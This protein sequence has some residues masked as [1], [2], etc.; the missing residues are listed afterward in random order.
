MIKKYLGII[1]A[2]ENRD[3]L[4]RLAAH[5][6]IAAIPVGGKYRLVD[7]VLSNMVNAGITS[8]AILAESDASSLRDH[9]GT[10]RAWDLNRRHGG[11]FVF[12]D[13]AK[14]RSTYDIKVLKENIEFLLRSKEEHVILS[15]T[16]L[17]SNFDL[18]KVMEEH[19]NSDAD[20]T[21]VYK[22]V[23]TADKEFLNLGAYRFNSDGTVAEIYKNQGKE[24]EANISMEM[25]VLS[26]KLLLDLIEKCA[27]INYSRNSRS[28]IYKQIE[29][30]KIK[31]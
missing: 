2:T 12:N 5:R 28:I 10:G 15:S 4:R 13:I 27:Y 14:E 18:K 19:E 6:S 17:I 1:S 8:V 23:H 3:N 11:I 30:L 21:A 31:G 22:K 9:I 20:I 26:K 7:F 24:K 25:F 29:K 16:H